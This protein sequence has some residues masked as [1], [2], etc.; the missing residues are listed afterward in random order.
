MRSGERD[1]LEGQEELEGCRR[2][3][4]KDIP[5]ACVTFSK[6][7]VKMFFENIVPATPCSSLIFALCLK[8]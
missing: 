3:Y 8:R 7:N 6:N 2:G 5:N 1:M 4:D